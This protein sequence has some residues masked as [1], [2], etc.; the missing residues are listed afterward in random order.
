MNIP[1][2]TLSQHFSGS[3]FTPSCYT[4][5]PTV[6]GTSIIGLSCSDSVLIA[7][8]TLGSYGSLS[9]FTSISRIIEVGMFFPFVVIILSIQFFL[10]HVI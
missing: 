4:N 1:F 6:T 9:R 2:T 8:D 10:I 5:H 7:T 3:N